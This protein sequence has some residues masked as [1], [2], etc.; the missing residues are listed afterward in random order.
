MNEFFQKISEDDWEEL[1]KI[2]CY[3]LSNIIVQEQFSVDEIDKICNSL[4]RYVPG[5]NFNEDLKER[6]IISLKRKYGISQNYVNQLFII[7]TDDE[8]FYLKF[9]YEFYKCDQFDGLI[10]CLEILDS[11]FG[12]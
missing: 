3:R 12:F 5:P 7:K 6:D 10:K 4:K 11:R 9:G 1:L 2:C 8:W